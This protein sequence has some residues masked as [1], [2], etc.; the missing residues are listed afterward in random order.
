MLLC[1]FSSLLRK[2]SYSIEQKNINQHLQEKS[3]VLKQTLEKVEETQE[4]LIETGKVAALGS[5]IAGLAHEV[6]TP[7]GVSVTA[8]SILGEDLEKLE[9]QIK[10]NRLRKSTFENFINSTKE[11][12]DVLSINLKRVS[13]LISLFKTVSIENNFCGELE[14]FELNEYLKTA[15]RTLTQTLETNNIE[16]D[17]QYEDEKIE[18]YTYQPTILNILSELVKNSI[19]HGFEGCEYQAKITIST[20]MKNNNACIK[21]CDNG[22]EIEDNVKKVIFDPF[23]TTKRNEGGIGLGLHIISNLVGQQLNGSI[24]LQDSEIKKNCF[25]IEIPRKNTPNPALT[26]ND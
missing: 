21:F 19:T 1:N 25:I 7:L 20:Y 9:L 2:V 11:V 6:N 4:Q 23:V 18:M 16:I 3:L 15:I 10:E 17:L 26:S 14:E 24:K 5:L 8:A 13:K 12:N 22:K